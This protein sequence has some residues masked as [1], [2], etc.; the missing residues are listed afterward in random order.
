MPDGSDDGRWERPLRSKGLLPA[1]GVGGVVYLV[2]GAVSMGTLAMVGIGAGVGYGVGSWLSE[3]Y[4][5]KKLQNQ[6]QQGGARGPG[7]SGALPDALQVSLMQWQAYLNSRAGG[8]E[9]TQQQLEQVFAEFAQREPVHAQNV[10]AVQG[11]VQAQ[12]GSMS[13]GFAGAGSTP[14]MNLN[15][16]AE[17]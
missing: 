1:L 17:V 14:V 9:L 3:Q 13:S 16:A 8:A 11:M 7:Q 15:A 10:Q 2:T 4:E 5:K 6:A 12:S